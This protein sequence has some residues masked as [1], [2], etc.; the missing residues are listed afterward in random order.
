MINT[1][2]EIVF[3]AGREGSG[4]FGMFVGL[5]GKTTGIEFERHCWVSWR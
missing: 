5:L 4:P 1:F 3:R 2:N